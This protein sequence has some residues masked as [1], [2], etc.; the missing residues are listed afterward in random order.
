MIASVLASPPLP[1]S[2]QARVFSIGSTKYALTLAFSISMQFFVMLFSSSAGFAAGAIT[3][4]AWAKAAFSTSKNT[5]SQ[6]PHASL[7][8]VFAVAGAIKTKSTLE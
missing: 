6:T 4:L 3:T 2:P 5:L 7:F 1:V 8:I